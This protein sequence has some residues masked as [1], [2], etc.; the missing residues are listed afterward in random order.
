MICKD[1]AAVAA[2]ERTSRL[3]FASVL[4]DG[5]LVVTDAE[6]FR[7]ALASGVGTSKAY[8]FGLLSIARATSEEGG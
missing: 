6:L 1:A 3:T 5:E 8:G 2:R 4:F 7:T